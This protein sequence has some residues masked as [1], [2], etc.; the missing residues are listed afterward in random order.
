MRIGGPLSILLL[1]LPVNGLELQPLYEEG[2]NQG[3]LSHHFTESAKGK[4]RNKYEEHDH[5]G[6]SHLLKRAAADFCYRLPQRFPMNEPDNR[7]FDNRENGDE[8]QE[9]DRLVERLPD[10][11][12]GPIAFADVQR[13]SDQKEFRLNGGL[14]DGEPPGHPADAFPFQDR[15]FEE[16]Q[17]AEHNEQVGGY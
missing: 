5:E 11:W 15:G 14:D 3:L 6:G 10:E 13:V 7:F 16:G 4:Q 2:A 1:H 17:C 8:S 12:L 9:D